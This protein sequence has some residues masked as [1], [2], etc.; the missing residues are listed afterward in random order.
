MTTLAVT[1]LT[2]TYGSTTAATGI[3]FDV[4]QGE[5]LGIVGE[6]GSG[7]S[8][9]L[10]CAALDLAPTTGSV[11]LAGED[12]TAAVGARRRRLRG[13]TIGIVRQA[14]HEELHLSVSAGGNIAER[15][16]ATGCRDFEEIRAR[17]EQ[18]YRAV[19]LPA[20]RIDAAVTTFSGGMRQRVQ[21]ARALVSNPQLLLLDEPT[22]GLDVSVQART[23]DLIRR[24]QRETQVAMVIV[25][26]DLAVIRMLADR[27][28]VMRR[29]RVV[30][31]GLTDQVLSDPQHAYT[32]LLVSSR[33][34]A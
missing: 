10:R 3:T 32:Q 31:S 6:S 24:L 18:V 16:L 25:S 15:L 1:D 7:K 2:V 12:V 17:V 23:L 29:G 9:V 28:L 13:E 34:E 22:T 30:E 26:H 19:E 21:I 5:V 14:A 11:H 33:L 27:L 20:E 8:T 4:Q